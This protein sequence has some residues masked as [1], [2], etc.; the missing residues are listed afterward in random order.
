MKLPEEEAFNSIITAIEAQRTDVLKA[1]LDT[2]I[3]N[4]DRTEFLRFLND[5]N[6]HGSFLHLVTRVISE[7]NGDVVSVLF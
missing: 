5:G 3:K 2:I 1:V 7:H 6:I 4:W